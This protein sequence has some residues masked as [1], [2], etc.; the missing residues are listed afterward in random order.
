MRFTATAKKAL[1]NAAG[2]SAEYGCPFIGTEHILLS[3]L[4]Y[5]EC[6]AFK[7]LT[8]RGVRAKP[9]ADVI[10]AEGAQSL[11]ESG[12]YS[13]RAMHALR[14]ASSYAGARGGEAGTEHILMALCSEDGCTAAKFISDQGVSVSELYSDAMSVIESRGAGRKR[15][16]KDDGFL[17]KYGK[18]LCEQYRRG[19]LDPCI[20][21]QSECEDVLRILCHRTKNAPCLIGEAGVG[22]T[23]VVEGVAAMLE[24]GDVPPSLLGKTIISVDMSAALSGAKYRGDFEER[25]HGIIDESAARGDVILFFDE[26]HTLIGAGAAE[27]ATDA[28]GMLKNV[29]GRGELSVIGATT[30]DEYERYVESD[31]ALSRRFSPVTVNE[32]DVEHCVVMLSGVKALYEH[33]HGVRVS[34]GALKLCVSLSSRYIKNRYLPDKALDL[35]DDACSSSACKRAAAV[36]EDDVREALRRRLG[37]DGAPC[38]DGLRERLS[39]KLAGQDEAISSICSALSRRQPSSPGPF[40]SLLFTGPRGVGKTECVK[41]IAGHVR[42]P[43]YRFDMSEY[44]EPHSV[45][46]LT[47]APPG[48]VGHDEGGALTRCAIRTPYCVICFENVDSA[49]ADVR[50]IIDQLLDFGELTDCRGRKVDFSGA[51]VIATDNSGIHRRAGFSKT[52]TPSYDTRFSHFDAVIRFKPLTKDDVVLIVKKRIIGSGEAFGVRITADDS[53][54]AYLSSLCSTSNA[55][56]DADRIVSSKIDVLL[57]GFTGCG[58]VLAALDREGKDIELTAV[59]GLDKSAV[60]E[61]NLSGR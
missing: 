8:A 44:T 47:G 55:Y 26:L 30:H 17:Q 24:R 2:L 57:G 23:A 12:G 46:V 32:P 9:V 52:D 1:E 42:R 3:L 40:V 50:A 18:D 39:E 13:V 56:R 14:Y 38:C 54:V 43:L 58:E 28:S 19:V 10:G 7:L 35:L 45:S 5:P 51:V 11:Y 20:G 60:L 25:F 29:L 33:H 21:R 34:D 16:L 6:A 49:H 48:Y 59:K 27:G 36:T 22:K 53:A 41:T 4:S 31:P 15:R 37:G 61:Y